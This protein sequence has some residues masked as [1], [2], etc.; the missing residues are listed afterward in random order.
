MKRFKPSD[1]VVCINDDF[2]NI[3]SA[4]K[5][6]QNLPIKRKS[7]LESRKFGQLG[8]VEPTS[9]MCAFLR[10]QRLTMVSC[11]LLFSNKSNSQSF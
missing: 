1:K 6:F 10:M 3:G 4:I 11:S 2:S 9:S 7:L 8:Q 5:D